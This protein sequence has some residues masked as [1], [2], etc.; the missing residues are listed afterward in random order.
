MCGSGICFEGFGEEWVDFYVA[1]IEN[2]DIRIAKGEA[3]MVMVCSGYREWQSGEEK[4][5]K[6]GRKKIQK[7]EKNCEFFTIVVEK[8]PLEPGI[9]GNSLK[10]LN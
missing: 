2:C 8:N 7:L 3:R 1:G 10:S 6:R 4:G 9:S 5:R